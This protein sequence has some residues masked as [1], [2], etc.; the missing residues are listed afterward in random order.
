M[1][2]LG[3]PDDTTS[4]Q[5]R[6]NFSSMVRNRTGWGLFAGDRLVSRAALSANGTRVGQTGGVFT[7][8]PYRRNGF[9]RATLCHM[10]KD[11]RDVHGHAKNVLFTGESDFPARRLYESLGYAAIG[12]FALVLG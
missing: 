5:K 8:A 11:C 10:L 3:L 2:E 9:A 1:A 6:L 12:E 7:A 4:E